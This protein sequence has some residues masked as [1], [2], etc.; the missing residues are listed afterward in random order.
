M[1]Q[2]RK[3]G[4]GVQEE[5]ELWRIKGVTE[6]KARLRKNR[7]VRAH[8]LWTVFG[9]LS[10]AYLPAVKHQAVQKPSGSTSI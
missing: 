6:G 9:K 8:A 5:S 1:S 7:V 10:Q 4:R 2:D 3:R